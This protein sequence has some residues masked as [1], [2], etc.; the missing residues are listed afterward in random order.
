MRLA[1]TVLVAAVVAMSASAFKGLWLPPG[2][3]HAQTG[4]G[5]HPGSR[6]PRRKDKA[7]P[8]KTPPKETATGGSGMPLAER[9]GIQ[10]DLAWTGP[11]Q[12]PESTASSTTAR[13]RPWKAFQKDFKFKENRHGW[14]RPRRAQARL[15]VE[16]QAGAG[17]LAHG[18]RQGDRR[19]GSACRPSRC[20][21]VSKGQSGTRW[22]S[23][24][25]TG[26]G[27]GRFR[28]REPG[29]TLQGRVRAAGRREPPKPQARGPTSCAT[30]S[31]SCRGWQGLKKFYVRGRRYADLEVARADHPL[32]SGHRRPSWIRSTVVMSRRVRAPSPAPG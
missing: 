23:A 1:G 25:G 20:R 11:L 15:H 5:N 16:D 32:R 26:P 29:M 10:L 13:W 9:V 3:A 27:R 12:R 6:K 14:R 18:R 22:A 4:E 8:K 30:T 31:S 19:A 2:A 21:N 28:L 17:R 7:A 24:Q